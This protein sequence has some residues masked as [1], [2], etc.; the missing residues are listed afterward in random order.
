MNKPR[1][2]SEAI[3]KGK[4][5]VGEV[6]ELYRLQLEIDIKTKPRSAELERFLS[7]TTTYTPKKRAPRK[8]SATKEKAGIQ[9]SS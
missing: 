2:L 5:T 4:P 9:A 1:I 8:H 3:L 6:A 7:Q